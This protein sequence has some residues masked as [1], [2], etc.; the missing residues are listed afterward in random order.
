MTVL[1]QTWHGL[2]LQSTIQS[3]QV[4]A[5]N[6]TSYAYINTLDCLLMYNDL[7]GNR[8]DL[9]MVSSAPPEENN[10]LLVYGMA[11]SGTWDTGYVL[12]RWPNT[13]DCGRLA[14]LPVAEQVQAVKDWNIGGY[15]IDHCLSSQR[16]KKNLCSVEYPSRYCLVGL[17]HLLNFRLLLVIHIDVV[18]LVVC[19]FNF[20]KCIGICY[21]ARYHSTPDDRPLVNIGDAICSFLQDPDKTTRGMSL[22]SKQQIAKSDEI[23]RTPTAQMYR[24]RQPRWLCAVSWKRW[25][26]CIGL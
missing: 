19:I 8:S 18:S 5:K 17:Y 21:T 10:T 3:M 14:E 24:F 26:L 22:V 25:S 23:W 7:M 4:N 2:D 12:C 1:L 9:I 13:F 15:K 6:G 16:S 20:L 11:A